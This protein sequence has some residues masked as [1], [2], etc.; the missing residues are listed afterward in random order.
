MTKNYE[1]NSQQK[2]VSDSLPKFKYSS[3]NFNRHKP[4]ITKESQSLTKFKSNSQSNFTL[5]KPQMT[6][7][8]EP[9][10]FESTSLSDLKA[11]SQ[12]F[13][14]FQEEFFDNVMKAMVLLLNKN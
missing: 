13:D 4:Q 9:R 5:K 14:D 1:P 10:N 12:Y 3:Q 11:N 7:K 8:F 6:R 2:L